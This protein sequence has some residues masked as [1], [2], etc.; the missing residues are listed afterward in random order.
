MATTSTRLPYVW[1]YDLDETQFRR[2]LAGELA[3]GRLDRGWAAIRLLK[4]APYR[5]IVRL[6]GFRDLL[7]GW[8]EWR[9]HIPLREPTAR[10]LLPDRV[11]RRAPSRAA[12]GSLDGF[13]SEP[14]LASNAGLSSFGDTSGRL[15]ACRR[16]SGFAAIGSSS[17][18][19]KPVS[20]HTFMWLRRDGTPN[21]G[22]SRSLSPKPKRSGITS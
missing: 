6:M 10:L 22:S 12:V 7:R 1:D 13:M 8:P 4:H 5:D 11:A 21:S 9:D 16:Y 17:S 14:G 15:R 18:A 19:W 2:L 20:R 3:L